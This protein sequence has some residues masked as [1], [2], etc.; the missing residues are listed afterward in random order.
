MALN[1]D[2]PLALQVHIVEYL[3]LKVLAGDCLCVLKKTI[4]QGTFTVVDMGDNA[5]IADILHRKIA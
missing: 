4:C 1:G 2:T 5:K 3:S